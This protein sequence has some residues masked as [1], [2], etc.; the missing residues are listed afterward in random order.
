MYSKPLAS[1]PTNWHGLCLFVRNRAETQWSSMN[2]KHEQFGGRDEVS[3]APEKTVPPAGAAEDIG[4]KMSTKD[5]ARLR[6]IADTLFWRAFTQDKG[7][8][9]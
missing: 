1:I 6:R 7:E 9:K 2:D 5:S 8:T 4:N 3:E